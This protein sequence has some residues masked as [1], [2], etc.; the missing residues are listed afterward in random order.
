MRGKV[1]TYTLKIWR[2]TRFVRP[3]PIY[4]TFILLVKRYRW[5]HV[6]TDPRGHVLQDT[7]NPVGLPTV[8]LIC[9]LFSS[10]RISDQHKNGSCR[11]GF[12]LSQ[13]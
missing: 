3:I 5:Q 2:E 9:L 10:R 11:L 13:Q 7:G 6:V 4:D 8:C 12:S 1:T